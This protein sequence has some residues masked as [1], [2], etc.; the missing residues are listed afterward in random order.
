[1][2]PRNRVVIPL[3]LLFG[4]AIDASAQEEAL[5]PRNANY[6][7]EVELHPETKM[8][9]GKLTLTWRNIR[10]IPTDE[11]RFHLYW[12]ARGGT[13][14]ARGFWSP[15]TEVAVEAFRTRRRVTTAIATSLPSS[16]F[17]ISEYPLLI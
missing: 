16:S 11:M 17:P 3:L 14:G 8:L 15:A 12:N 6:R 2:L 13:T 9:E 10:E 1:M 4:I 7:I 5:S